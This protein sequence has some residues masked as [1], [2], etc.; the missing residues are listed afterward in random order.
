MYIR[1]KDI[2]VVISGA[3]KGRRG[4]VLQVYPKTNRVLV[5]GVNMIRRHTRPN[6]RNQSGGIVEK[7]API[8][9]SNVMPWCEDKRRPSKIVMKRLEDGTRIRVWKI[10]GEAVD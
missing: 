3:D 6:R 4:R 1:K 2:V 10:S 7:E 9:I 5:E 8:H